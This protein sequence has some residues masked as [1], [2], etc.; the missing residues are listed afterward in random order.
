VDLLAQDA[1]DEAVDCLDRVRRAPAEARKATVR[2]LRTLAGARPAA[3]GGICSALPPFLR[4]EERSVRLTTAKLFVALA[5]P[6]PAAVV[7]VVPSLADRLADDEE[8]YYVRARAAEALGYVAL[9]YPDAVGDPEI[10]ADLRVGLSFDEPAVREKLAKALECVA[11]GDPERL[12]HQV[13]S[14][15]GHLDDGNELVRYHLSTALVAIGCASPGRLAPARDRLVERLDDE[16]AHV[17][18]RAAEA[19]GVLAREQS[20]GAPPDGLPGAIAAEEAPFVVER[21]RFAI[22]SMERS[23]R[24]ADTPDTIGTRDGVR[25]TTAEAVD[26]IESPDRDGACPQCGLERPEGAPPMCPRCG[27]PI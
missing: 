13:S 19:L 23:G 14:L 12:R 17:R 9:E 20:D 24:P 25:T 7:P 22:D 4:D 2:S 5:E 11:L 16:N 15:A 6:T 18:G 26:A 1:R 10:L 27:S 8:F 21:V 3:V